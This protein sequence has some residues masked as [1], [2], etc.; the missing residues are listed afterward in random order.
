MSST[1]SPSTDL[2]VPERSA[3][4][5]GVVRVSARFG[6][7]FAVLQLVVM[8]A[9]STMIL[10]R[11]GSPTD[12][13]LER[14][15]H[16]LGARDLYVAGNYALALSCLL[17]LGFLGVVSLRLRSADTTGV[18]ATVAVAAGTL[19]AV[20][21]PLAAVIHS[22]FLG[23]A[24]A[25]ADIRILAGADAIAPFCL[26]LT[27]LARCFFVAAIVLALR[28]TG[29]HVVLRR[30]GV[31]VVVLSLLGSATMV[32]GEAFPALALSSLGFEVWVGVLAW[33]WLRTA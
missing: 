21:W 9:F 19:V 5:P 2:F 24:D 33:R 7:V 3:G 31:A 11:G 12:P 13:V 29:E 28:A 22:V 25:G 30:T 27:A 1:V 14:G 10:P 20:I 4:G 17:L 16:I 15:A 23:I 32:V 18:L 26:A 6:V 8:V